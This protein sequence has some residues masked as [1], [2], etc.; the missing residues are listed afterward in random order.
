MDNVPRRKSNFFQI[1]TVE[2]KRT[3]LLRIDLDP[4][5]PAVFQMAVE[6]L[7]LGLVDSLRLLHRASQ[8]DSHYSSVMVMAGLEAAN[9]KDMANISIEQ[10]ELRLG[11]KVTCFQM[12]SKYSA[13]DEQVFMVLP[14]SELGLLQEEEDYA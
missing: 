8:V 4:P 9:W 3:G 11:H 12:V 7:N 14:A 1:K 5:Q 10:E 6:A 13:K 2:K